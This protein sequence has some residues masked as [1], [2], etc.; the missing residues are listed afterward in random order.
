MTLS[1]QL[2]TAIL[3]HPQHFDILKS[4]QEKWFQKGKIYEKEIQ[5]NPIQSN[6]IQSNPIQSNPIVV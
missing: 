5:S 2:Q 4:D 3:T 6:P 1:E